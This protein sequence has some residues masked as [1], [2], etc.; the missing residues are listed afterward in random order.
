MGFSE[1][2]PVEFAAAGDR[3][4]T[5]WAEPDSI[6]RAVRAARKRADVVVA[7][8]HWGIE[9]SGLESAAQQALAQAAVDAGA[10]LVIGAHPHVLQPLRRE[11]A[12]LV[13]YSL[14]NFVFGAASSDT[15]STGILVTDL[16]A[17]GVSGA[18]WRPGQIAGGRPELDRSPP[19]RL[20]LGD[21]ASM[22]AGVTL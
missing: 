8:F 6:A 1:I 10:Q 17:D 22:D 20:P 3:P 15:T 21:P 4:G 13:A 7:T 16:T 5:A 11:G 2:A 18:R 14:G 19:R 9:K 12:A